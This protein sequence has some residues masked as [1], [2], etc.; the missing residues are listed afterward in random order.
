MLMLKYFFLLVVT[1][2]ICFCKIQFVF[3]FNPL[4]THFLY[5]CCYKLSLKL[6]SCFHRVSFFFF[7][8]QSRYSFCLWFCSW[9]LGFHCSC[10][11][12]LHP[13]RWPVGLPKHSWDHCG[14]NVL[15]SLK[16]SLM[17]WMIY[18]RFTDMFCL[19]PTVF[20]RR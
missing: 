8:L 5:F 4:A 18:C 3:L 20:L 1:V 2:M 14:T 16:D 15:M 10:R 6:H 9:A 19:L 12:S 13:S 11:P 17:I 7:F